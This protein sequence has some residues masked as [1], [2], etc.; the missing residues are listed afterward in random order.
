M[1]EEALSKVLSSSSCFES[2]MID[3]Q[4]TAGMDSKDGIECHGGAVAA[5]DT[6]AQEPKYVL[7]R[8]AARAM[9]VV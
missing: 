6:R 4:M 3:R 8:A 9:T 5:K 1:V 2:D 7:M